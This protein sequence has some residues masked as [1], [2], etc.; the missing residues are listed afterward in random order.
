MPHIRQ[1]KPRGTEPPSVSE[2]LHSSV[3]LSTVRP[4]ASS[5]SP[6][7]PK[8]IA[9]VSTVSEEPIWCTVVVLAPEHGQ[10]A[11][12]LDATPL[13]VAQGPKSTED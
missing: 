2:K 1:L 4:I 13:D 6:R 12:G 10:E 9:M 5:S 7:P 8:T 3:L 11:A